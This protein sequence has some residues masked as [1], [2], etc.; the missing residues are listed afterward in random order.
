M[1]TSSELCGKSALANGA[2]EVMEYNESH[3]WNGE[4]FHIMNKD[5]LY[6]ERGAGYWL[7]KPLI[8][9]ENLLDMTEN[10]I[11]VYADAGIEFKAPLK[12]I[13]HDQMQN[14]DY[15]L[16]TNGHRNAEWSKMDILESIIPGKWNLEQRQIQASV[17]FLRAT[18]PMIDFAKEWLLWCQMPGLIDDS[19]SRRLNVSTFAENRHDQAILT[20]VAIKYGLDYMRWWPTQYSH[21]LTRNKR[22]NYPVLFNH[23][24]KRESDWPK[25]PI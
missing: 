5:V 19:P 12:H 1:K 22:D 21:H 11:V 7:W 18:Q 15:F 10:D 20:A 14:Q 4:F 3:I 8:I 17:I 24:R 6:A 16:F 13:V 25:I 9:V 23:H 2:D